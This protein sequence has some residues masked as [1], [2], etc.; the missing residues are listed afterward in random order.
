MAQNRIEVKTMTD[1]IKLANDREFL[2]QWDVGQGLIVPDGVS[3]VH[4]GTPMMENFYVFKVDD[5]HY[6]PILDRVLQRRATE[7]IV[8]EYLIDG[9]DGHTM[10]RTTFRIKSRKKP[11]NYQATPDQAHSLEWWTEQAE[12]IIGDAVGVWLDEHP[13]VTTTLQ[14]GEVTIPKLN[15]QVWDRIDQS[16]DQVETDLESQINT[17]DTNK[18]DKTEVNSLATEKADKTV[19][20]ALSERVSTAENDI[21]V[22]DA[23][24]DTF[25]SL[26][27]GSTSGNAELL[28][29][30]VGADGETY[31]SAGGAVR[32]QISNLKCDLNLLKEFAVDYI[33]P[34]IANASFNGLT[35][36]RQTDGTTRISG[37][38]SGTVNKSLGSFKPKV[39]KTYEFV[40]NV[41]PEGNYYLYLKGVN[42][43]TTWYRNGDRFT[44]TQD[45]TVTCFLAV[46]EANE[47]SF[48]IQP[49]AI[50]VPA[51]TGEY[52]NDKIDLTNDIN[53][54]FANYKYAITSDDIGLEFKNYDLSPT[55]EIVANNSRLTTVN[56][57]NTKGFSRVTV[58][59]PTGYR[60]RVVAYKSINSIA[61][62]F[63][64]GW[65]SEKTKTYD[66]MF[67]YFRILFAKTSGNISP[68]EASNFTI[69][70][71]KEIT[72]HSEKEMSLMM[73]KFISKDIIKDSY[74]TL[75]TDPT[76]QYTYSPY[77][78]SDVQFENASIWISS[79]YRCVPGD[80]IELV[81][82]QESTR[83]ILATFGSDGVLNHYEVGS[84]INT[85]VKINY[86]FAD[87][88][89]YFRV[90]CGRTMY[91]FAYV[92]YHSK[93][94]NN[95]YVPDYAKAEYERV[96]SELQSK[97]LLG[98]P[99]VFGFNT[100][101][102]TSYKYKEQNV[103]YGLRTL[104]MLS[105]E[106][107]F[108][109]HCL[110]GDA[111]SYSSTD[112]IDI[113]N[114]VNN[115]NNQMIGSS[116]PV[117][118]IVGNHDAIDNNSSVTN[119]ELYNVTF[120]RAINE[121]LFDYYEAI[122]CN[123]YID[124]KMHSVRYIFV[125]SI[126]RTGYTLADVNIFLETALSNM[127]T[128]YNAVIISHRKLNLN[129]PS[130]M[131]L[132]GIDCAEV[133]ERYA[134]RI[135]I[136]INGHSHKDG[137]DTINGILYV[138]TTTSGLDGLGTGDT[139]LDYLG[140]GKETAYDVFV[141]D[142][143]EK[144]VFAVRY[145]YGSNREWTYSLE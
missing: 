145:G 142:Q 109:F 62:D 8:Y 97:M 119:A 105:N 99:I 141:I 91:R 113:L 16:I 30:R 127:P 128:G 31:Q 61:E 41:S 136:C 19:V 130:E 21:D 10:R 50:E 86:T 9:Q 101:Q 47:V 22:L 137:S 120:K 78:A 80:S 126:P 131:G 7:L 77:Q 76:S 27:S 96:L 93:F 59:A 133:L 12:E 56:K 75:T 107:P 114:D 88:D 2:W 124:S 135:I 69:T 4:Y 74:G 121:R 3:E 60:F 118:P 122:G 90:T 85:P 100:D 144:K 106:I 108:D 84:G 35:A 67:P 52:L 54:D 64:F 11:A 63:S 40:S 71:S 129:L 140:T 116:C 38:P 24:M 66:L 143:T 13:D 37:T 73:D 70:F 17:L 23:R 95:Q 112:V 125:D 6:I 58:T 14:D 5:T 29:I 1:T 103:L 43:T 51:Y 138:S 46:S 28:D 65:D 104:K 102:H 49:L 98:N 111:P 26:P 79:I 94:N 132:D 117:I 139:M 15:S 44:V 45:S 87:S 92:K 123:A 55:E 115:V 36:T 110:G 72:D 34:T 81:S 20:N 25:A 18:A 53:E 83:Y 68:S 89:K 33:Y 57:I 42:G 32:G 48:L 82:S 39:G 134:S